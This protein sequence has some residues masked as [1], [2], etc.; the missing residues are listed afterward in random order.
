[1]LPRGVLVL[2]SGHDAG[3]LA[4]LSWNLD[5]VDKGVLVLFK[6][7]L[8]Q[9]GRLMILHNGHVQN[10][11]TACSVLR[12]DNQTSLE[13]LGEIAGVGRGD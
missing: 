4:E 13:H 1:M 10:L 2:G 5:C 7:L 6:G 9:V 8:S 3:N 11:V 12:L